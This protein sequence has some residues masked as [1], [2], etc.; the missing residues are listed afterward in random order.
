MTHDLIK[1]TKN[2]FAYTLNLDVRAPY[3]FLL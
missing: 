1:I 2:K 3:R